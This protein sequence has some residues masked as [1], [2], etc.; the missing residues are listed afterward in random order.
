MLGEHR[1]GLDGRPHR[2]PPQSEGRAP[3]PFGA[4]HRRRRSRAAQRHLRETVELDVRERLL[5]LALVD[6]AAARALEHV[7]QTLA[8]AIPAAADTAVVRDEL[9]EHLRS[10]LAEDAECSDEDDHLER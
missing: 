5:S 9:I 7:T 3:L 10:A 2:P 8:Q 4:A 6:F 1:S